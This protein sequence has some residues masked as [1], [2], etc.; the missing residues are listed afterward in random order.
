MTRRF[1]DTYFWL[2]YLNPH[3]AG[4]EQASLWMDRLQGGV[5]TTEWVLLEVA[6]AMS[7]PKNR[8]AV[9]AFIESLQEDDGFEIV[10]FNDALRQLGFER[11]ADRPDKEWSMTDCVS[12]VVMEREEIREALTG[13]HHFEQAGFVALLK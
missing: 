3:D 6:D 1:A 7:H 2:A 10:D 11:F 9:V 5:V 8:S 13:D 12:F 4:H